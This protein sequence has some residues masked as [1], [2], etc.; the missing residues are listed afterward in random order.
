MVLGIETS[1][2]ETSA[3]VI[4]KETGNPFVKLL[5]HSTASS[6]AQHAE[7]GGVIPE[8]AAR[9]QIQYIIPI[10]NQALKEA[11]LTRAI[12]AIAVTIG[13]GLIGSLLVGVE[14]AKTLA[15]VWN[16]P[17]VP[18]NHLIGHIYANWIEGNQ[19]KSILF[20]ALALIVSGGHTDLVLMKSHKHIQWLGGTKDDASGEA[21]DKIGR[22]INFP[23]PAG[24]AF[25]KAAAK[26]NPQA[27]HFPRPIMHDNAFDFSFSG[28]KTAA[29]R[30][31]YKHKTLDDQTR[32]NIARGVQ[33]AIIDVLVYKTCNAAEKH[34]VTSILL[35]GGV[36][37][38]QM[39][40]DVLQ[41][42]I[43]K[44]ELSVQF[45]APEK[46]LCTDNAAM[47]A[48]AGYFNNKPIPWKKVSADSELYFEG[49]NA[50]PQAARMALNIIRKINEPETTH[51]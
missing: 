2:D 6:M 20:P 39:L 50:S 35:S 25:E 19:T 31:I 5:S 46:F 43:K 51:F 8:I 33:D 7:T 4:E 21:I 41:K 45:F 34:Q 44:R 49:K 38:N 15:F 27:Y 17:I 42:E 29:L 1:C 22:R 47:I 13:P 32:A 28:L 14:T 23:Y 18:V 30:E 37:A 3:A 40:R 12:D 11:Q 24:P 9:N 10:I 36:A 16:K 48:A 26:G